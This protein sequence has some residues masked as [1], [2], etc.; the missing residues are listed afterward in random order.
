MGRASSRRKNLEDWAV[1]GFFR[2]LTWM[3][4]LVP[5]S[6]AY[7]FFGGLGQWIAR[8]DAK[9]RHI[10]LVN[11]RIAFPDADDAWRIEV[12]ERSYRHLGEHFVELARLAKEPAERLIE[13][14]SY[15]PNRGLEN[16][17]EARKHGA[18]LFVT[19]HVSAWEL[20][21]Q[22]HALRARPLHFV[23]RPLDNPLLDQWAT[24]LRERF[25]NRV[26]P[27]Q[28]AVRGMLARLRSGEDVG[29][30]I[31]QNVQAKEGVF[32]EMF[33]HVACTT[34]A[35]AAL[36]LKTGCWAVPAFLVPTAQ[37]GHYHIRFYPPV[38]VKDGADREATLRYWTQEFTGFIEHVIRDFPHC[39]LWGHRR[40]LTQ[41]DGVNPYA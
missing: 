27:K 2:A 40:F 8:H 33:G 16:Y 23:V 3:A 15:E 12:F 41:P 14:I 1:Y 13:R 31:D 10:A 39:W 25:G 34:P 29:V 26:L 11:L 37:V 19:A 22:G 30:L 35:A 6:S 7:R 36:A 17:E 21:P 9:H 5:P 32:I 38:E 28:G 20:L 18:V 4:G 24:K